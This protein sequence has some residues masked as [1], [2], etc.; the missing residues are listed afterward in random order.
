M[1]GAASAPH[2]TTHHRRALI[3]HWNKGARGSLRILSDNSKA[4]WDKGEQ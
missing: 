4:A 3:V 2:A 1:L